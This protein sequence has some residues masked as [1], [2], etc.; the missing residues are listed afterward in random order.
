MAWDP[1]QYEK[2][3]REREQPFE[4]LIAL[5]DFRP[6][7][8]MVDL[9]CGTGELT[10]KV[11][12]RSPGSTMLGVDSSA[13]M[14]A[15][16]RQH[17]RP[18]LAFTRSTVEAW[19]PGRPLDVIFSHAALQWV[20]AHESLF[21]R[22]ARALAPGGRLLVQMPSNHGHVSHATVREL[23]AEAPWSERFAGFVRRSPVLEIGAYADMLHAA[24]L[25]RP[26]VIEKVYGH[27]LP[28]SDAV[29][30]WIKGTLLVPYL[31]R[32]NDQQS[33]EF[34][35]ELSRRFRPKM[36]QKPYY[37]GFRRILIAARKS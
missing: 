24:G 5:G 31:E 30:E 32:L 3:K 12:A 33:R 37:F 6:G 25:E 19:E 26:T 21:P 7:E 29:L 2:F 8:L 9:G 35:D 34:L 15:K 4:D 13:E 23:A 14:L 11:A 22:L 17:E 20:D 27:V 18:G 1:A 16:A 36:P 28:D 10:A